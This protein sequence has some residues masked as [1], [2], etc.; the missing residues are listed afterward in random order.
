M[1]LVLIKKD[2]IVCSFTS[3]IAFAKL[4]RPRGNKVTFSTD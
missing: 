1:Q 2:S 3:F 4:P